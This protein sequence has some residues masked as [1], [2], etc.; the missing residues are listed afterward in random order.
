MAVSI[1][2]EDQYR[3]IKGCQGMVFSGLTAASTYQTQ[4]H[5]PLEPEFSGIP[6]GRIV[7]VND[8]GKFS[9]ECP[10][11]APGR[12]AMPLLLS[13]GGANIASV[14]K[15][16]ESRATAGDGTDPVY[17]APYRSAIPQ[18]QPNVMALP[19]CVGYEYM[20]TEY[21]KS[22]VNDYTYNTALTS[23]TIVTATDEDE[24]GLVIPLEADDKQMCIGFVSR[25]PGQPRTYGDPASLP[26]NV[27]NPMV[28]VTGKNTPG[29]TFWGCPF[30]C[31]V[32]TVS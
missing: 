20:S 17:Y 2:F 23:K 29:L 12:F 32:V 18:P 11:A 14:R 8:D 6:N 7:Y 10:V 24:I 13:E 26:A 19:L 25:P 15:T 21:D 3:G 22:I 27:P 30:P 4:Y 31:G 9:P 28:A 1:N 5:A 16:Y